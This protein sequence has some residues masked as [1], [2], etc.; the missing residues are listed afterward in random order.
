VD[1]HDPLRIIADTFDPS[2][3]RS[4][5]GDGADSAAPF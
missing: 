2:I 4:R 5:D 3:Y 1:L